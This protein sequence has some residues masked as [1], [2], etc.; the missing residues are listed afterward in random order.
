MMALIFCTASY[1]GVFGVKL[2]ELAVHV[3]VHP[4]R[5]ADDAQ[6]IEIGHHP[7]RAGH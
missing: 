5:T 3:A 2:G 4:A 1:S 7:D 6:E